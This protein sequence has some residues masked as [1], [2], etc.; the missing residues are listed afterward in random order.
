MLA[1]AVPHMGLKGRTLEPSRASEV[2]QFFLAIASLWEGRRQSSSPYSPWSPLGQGHPE[3]LVCAAPLMLATFCG[4]QDV[5][6]L[7]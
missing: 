2:T 4:V 6:Q 3:P 1:R 5:R 7:L